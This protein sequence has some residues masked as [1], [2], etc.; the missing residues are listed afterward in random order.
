MYENFF[1]AFQSFVRDQDLFSRTMLRVDLLQYKNF[2]Y[3]ACK[4]KAIDMKSKDAI[5]LEIFC[6]KITQLAERG[7]LPAE[8]PSVIQSM[9]SVHLAIGDSTSSDG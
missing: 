4:I 8:T 9:L 7:K 3:S 1:A 5:I 2:L 6:Q